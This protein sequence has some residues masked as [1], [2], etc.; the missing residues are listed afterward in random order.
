MLND[1]GDK[2][3]PD[4][5][6]FVA[7]GA[8]MA[9]LKNCMYGN[10]WVLRQGDGKVMSYGGAR[11]WHCRDCTFKRLEKAAQRKKESS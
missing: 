9:G 7:R 11:L 8:G 10:H 1:S 2:K 6:A 5:T 4:D 3:R